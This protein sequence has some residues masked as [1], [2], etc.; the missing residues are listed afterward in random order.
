M[1]IERLPDGQRRREFRSAVSLLL[2]SAWD[3]WPVA[4]PRTT[5]WCCRFIA[6]NDLSPKA[7]H[8][9]WRQMTGL[10]ENDAG[11]SDHEFCLRLL[12]TALTFDQLQVG[13]LASLEIVM[14]K[15]QLTELKHRDRVVSAD[16]KV[17]SD[18]HL[19]LGTGKTRGLLMVCPALEDYVAAELHRESSAAKERRKMREERQAARA[20]PGKK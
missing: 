20:P 6:E 13:E 5:L 14:R 17:E 7:R 1:A 11:V 4:G 18:E 12:E 15:A 8:V 19:Y 16:F 3:G 9:R 2:E 10:N